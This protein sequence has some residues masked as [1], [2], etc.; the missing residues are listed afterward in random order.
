VGGASNGQGLPASRCASIVHVIY[1]V[2]CLALSPRDWHSSYCFNKRKSRVECGSG[3]RVAAGK[4]AA[5]AAVSWAGS[6]VQRHA[7]HIL[8]AACA[9]YNACGALRKPL[10]ARPA[11]LLRA[12]HLVQ[13]GQAGPTMELWMRPAPPADPGKHQFASRQETFVRGAGRNKACRESWCNR[14]DRLAQS[15]AIEVSRISP[16]AN[17]GIL[18][19]WPPTEGRCAG[20]MI[21][22]LRSVC[23]T[24]LVS[25]NING[26]PQPAGSLP[27]R[28]RAAARPTSS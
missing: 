2:T 5:A 25:R 4:Q 16:I 17:S 20:L 22:N 18:L 28:T 6:G 21:D 10:I 14:W 9:S 13:W 19:G 8:A 27:A 24:D 7:A 11:G 23:R 1:P 12:G 15:V 3:R 26:C